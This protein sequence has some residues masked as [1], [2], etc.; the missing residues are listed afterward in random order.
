MRVPEPKRRHF[1]L[2]ARRGAALIALLTLMSVTAVLAGV[3][4]RKLVAERRHQR[5]AEELVQVTWLVDSGL[6]RA[7]AR[8]AADPTFTEEQWRV[9]AADLG[10]QSDAIVMLRAEPTEDAASRFRISAEARY[11]ADGP[12]IKR[13]KSV[14]I[15]L[16]AAEPIP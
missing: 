9:S 6:R 11:P 1:T 13:S 2:K 3:W 10:R 4:A 7:A 15:S 8:L 14:N 12:R 16:P 5:R